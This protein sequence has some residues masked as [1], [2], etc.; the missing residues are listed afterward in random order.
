MQLYYGLQSK[1]SFVKKYSGKTIE[2]IIK[3]DP[4]YI[5]WAL[6]NVAKFLLTDEAHKVYQIAIEK[7]YKILE[8]R[9]F[10]PEFESENQMIK[11]FF[12]DGNR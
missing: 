4:A 10:S 12:Q 2:E 1:P 11:G 9:Y 8:E 7:Y 6:K 5:E 3:K